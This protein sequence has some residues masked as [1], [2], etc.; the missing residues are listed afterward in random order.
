[1]DRQ[2]ERTAGT[3]PGTHTRRLVAVAAV[4]VVLA[5]LKAAGAVAV[6]LVFALFLAAV[7]WPLQR[8]LKQRLP[9]GLA[10]VLTLLAFLAVLAVLV[11]AFAAAIDTVADDGQPYFTQ[12]EHL[13]GDV[14]GWLDARGIPVAGGPQGGGDELRTRALA[15][16]EGAFGLV[17]AFVLVLALFVLGLLEVMDARHKLTAIAGDRAE[18]WLAAVRRITDDFQRYIAVRT[19]VGLITGAATG[20]VCL[21]L[22]LEF[23]LVWGLINFL[24][25]YIP[26]IGSIVGVVPPVLFALVQFEGAG[27]ALAVLAA[28]GGVQLVM[29]NWIDPLLQGRFLKL[30]PFVVLLSVV[31]WGWLW[32]IAGA[33][34]SMPITV[35]VVIAARQSE[36]TRWLAI[37][38]GGE[39]P[40][41]AGVPD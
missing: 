19:L 15:A 37:L 31:F 14:R 27:R 26:T 9:A 2:T 17:S 18:R 32:G 13:I 35:A 21:A 33:F 23:A 39:P 20:A 12:I 6:P 1:M 5:G 36:R 25:N 40:P 4:V 29:G 30:S 28:V 8:R 7:F 41:D 22:G 24:L 11:G 3:A 16:V 34:L 38:L 10:A